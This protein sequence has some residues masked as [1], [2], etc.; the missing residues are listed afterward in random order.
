MRTKFDSKE[1]LK[2]E[3]DDYIKTNF[4]TDLVKVVRMSSRQGLIRARLAGAKE[5]KAEILVFFDSHIETGVNWLPPLIEPIAKDYKT[6]MCPFIDVIGDETFTITI[7]DTGSRGAF[8]W[9]GLAEAFTNCS[10]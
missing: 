8:D 3:L 9:Y 5:A 10:D 4:K 2:H 1:N 7:Q 6:V